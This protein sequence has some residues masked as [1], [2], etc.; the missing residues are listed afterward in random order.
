M[1][2]GMM[3]PIGSGVLGGG[4]TARWSE[5][6]EMAKLAEAVGFE[7]LMV[8]DHLLFRQSPPGN[9]PMVHLPPGKTRGIW[10]AWSVLSAAAEATSRIQLG[11]LMAC[12]S[13]RNPTL[14]AKM[15][16]TLDEISG[17]RLV[18]GLGA[19]WHEPEYHAFG[20]P[21]DRR[22][23]RFEEALQI[24]VT[25]LREGRIDFQGQYYQ[26]RDCE[27]LPRG[28]RPGGPPI[29][30][31][32][33]KP[34]MLRLVARHADIYDTDYQYGAEAVVQRYAALGAACADVGRDP[35][36][37]T[38]S[39]A[40]RVAVATGS[41]PDPTWQVSPPRDGIA[42]YALDG[43]RFAAR[44]G[45]PD[46]LAAYLRTFVAAGAERITVN[47]VDPPGARGIERFAPVVDALRR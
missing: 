8:P 32:A 2:L 25:L 31:G 4:R 11:P 26:A 1:K 21:F 27:L 13:F 45:T 24:I 22:V 18:L 19:G 42:E 40:T 15:A 44:Y 10:E 34:R 35:K 7:S 29:M 30:I 28:P 41:A 20:F 9:D 37:L 47:V 36:T 23:S 46:E 43:A 39:T 17:G 5:L 3:L 6:R 33:Q 12:A 14:L 38:R 16:A